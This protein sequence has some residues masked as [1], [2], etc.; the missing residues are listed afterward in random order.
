[1]RFS[2]PAAMAVEYCAT[3]DL[4]RPRLFVSDSL[5]EDLAALNQAD[6]DEDA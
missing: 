2:R 4:N 5:R 6:V 1:M 3:H